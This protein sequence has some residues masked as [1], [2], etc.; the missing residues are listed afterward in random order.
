MALIIDWPVALRPAS[1]EWGLVH[2]QYLG[3][4]SFDSSVQAQTLGA[5]RWAF[6]MSTGVLR[7]DEVPAWE[8]L[9]DQL[10]GQV[11]R[12]RCWDWRREAPLGPATTSGGSVQVRTAA[13]G[14]TINSKGWAA[15]VAGILRAGSMLGV[16][17]EL[18]RLS[19]DANSDS[20]GHATLTVRP[21]MRA[22]A[23][24]D[25][26]ITLVKPTALFVMTT[27]RASMP[28]EGAR[29]T[30]WTLSFEEVPA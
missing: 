8:A 28:Q 13:T 14:V 24:V 1:V 29:S 5:P 9:I 19:V 22:T 15:S 12:V 11:N 18:K 20:S 26:V 2:S 23:P 27:Q 17:G 6:T 10:D 4:S 30:G 25:A 21:P 3:R 16:N 7:H